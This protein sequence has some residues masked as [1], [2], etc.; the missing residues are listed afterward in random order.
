MSVNGGKLPF[1]Q[2]FQD[3]K[4]DPR[5][6]IKLTVGVAMMEVENPKAFPFFDALC[7]TS[8]PP[9]FGFAC[10]IHSC[11]LVFTDLREP[12]AENLFRT[13]GVC[14]AFC[15]LVEDEVE[16]MISIAGGG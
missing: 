8:F 9:S 2:M 1:T 3:Q 12:R 6:L 15:R 16:D 13:L 14:P 7:A 11:S 4:L 10:V 5:E